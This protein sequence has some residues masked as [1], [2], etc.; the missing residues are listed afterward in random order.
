MLK[1]LFVVTKG[2]IKRC[3]VYDGLATRIGIYSLK[4]FTDKIK[5]KTLKMSHQAVRSKSFEICIG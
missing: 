4:K 1:G 3:T 2:P 5:T